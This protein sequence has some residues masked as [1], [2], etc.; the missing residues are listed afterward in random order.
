[1]FESVRNQWEANA[2]HYAGLV[3]DH[4][5]PHHQKILNPCVE[6]LLGDVAGKKMLDAGCGEGY[7]TR[8]YA[9]KQAL[10]T[11]ID[12]SEKLIRIAKEKSTESQPI[13][14]RI[15]NIC[16]MES[17][18]TESFD[19]VLC[20]LVILNVPCLSEAL[21][22]FNR[23]LVPEGVLV[24]SIVHPAFN[25]YGPGEWE[26][27]EKDLRTN[28]RKGFYFKVDHYTDEKPYE[29]YWRTRKGE[30]FPEPITFY[31][32]TISTYI[33]SLIATGFRIDALKEPIPKE[34]DRFFDREK[35]IPFFMVIKAIKSAAVP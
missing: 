13:D 12:L 6:E 30:R 32:R 35:R 5:T 24:F 3:S 27:G 26:L 34:D 22:E 16:N 15:A 11:G 8:Y 21:S 28:R 20:N 17:I 10:M 19:I 33:D 14:Y 31:H 4:G 7:L 23:V 29:R 1:M 18:D 25:I 9:G 2:K